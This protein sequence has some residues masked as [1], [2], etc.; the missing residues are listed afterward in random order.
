MSYWAH[1]SAFIEPDASIGDRTRIW[2]LT[3]VRSRSTVGEDCN[4]GKNCFIDSGAVIG[5]RVKVQNNVSVYHGVIIEDDVFVGPCA[6]FTNDYYPRAFSTDWQVKET[7]V[8]KGASIGA[9][10]TLICGI[11]I[12]SYAMVGAGSVVTRSVPPHALVAGN[13]AR[14]IGWFCQCGQKLDA[15]GRCP[16]CGLP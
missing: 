9:N 8:R 10:A 7:V 15:A 2:H 6:V 16:A 13:P 14:Q 11:T 12:G 1:D 4:I 3:Q 5:N